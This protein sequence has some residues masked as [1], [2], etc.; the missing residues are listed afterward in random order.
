MYEVLKNIIVEV[1]QLDA[2]DV[3]PAASREDVGLDSIS[4]V[5]LSMT[6]SKRYGIDITDEE[7]L[8]SDTMADIARLMEKRAASV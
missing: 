8:E 1:L 4:I 2:D 7:L 3:R 5:E 6:L